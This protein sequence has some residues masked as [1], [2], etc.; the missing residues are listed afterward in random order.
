[1]PSRSGT[2]TQGRSD[3]IITQDLVCDLYALTRSLIPDMPDDLFKSCARFN[4]SDSLLTCASIHHFFSAFPFGISSMRA[5][6]RKG[7][8]SELD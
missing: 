4:S 6:D 8:S 1:V 2:L 5:H 3:T 7:G